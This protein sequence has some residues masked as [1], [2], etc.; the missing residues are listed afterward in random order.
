MALERKAILDFMSYF[1]SIFLTKTSI[2][3]FLGARNS[4]M[5]SDL[6]N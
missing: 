3:M 4:K 1:L 6:M 5:Q 2:Y